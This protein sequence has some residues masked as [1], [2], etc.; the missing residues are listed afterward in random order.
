[1]IEN[2]FIAICAR[3]RWNPILHGF[4]SYVIFPFG[5][6]SP[7]PALH[8]VV[9]VMEIPLNRTNITF[10]LLS[11]N[12]FS[13]FIISHF[14]HVVMSFPLPELLFPNVFIAIN[15]GYIESG[16]LFPCLK[17]GDPSAYL[18]IVWYGSIPNLSYQAYRF[19]F[20]SLRLFHAI[21]VFLLNAFEHFAI[22]LAQ[23]LQ[24]HLQQQRVFL[25]S[26]YWII[27]AG[28]RY[29]RM[30]AMEVHLKLDFSSVYLP[31]SSLSLVCPAHEGNHPQL[32]GQSN[33]FYAVSGG[34]HEQCE[35]WVDEEGSRYLRSRDK[36]NN[37]I[38]ID[39]RIADR[40]Q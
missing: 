27:S 4:W 29:T 23:L 12:A 31:R 19:H 18:F 20:D 8:S 32:V 1:M 25:S 11:Q 16:K 10:G 33:M 14:R 5:R 9:V 2:T 17:A 6:T 28:L 22:P 36:R 7:A 38:E 3:N 24:E 30:L 39:Q 15:V 34:H 26:Y 35:G 37:F 40:D 13:Y 21:G